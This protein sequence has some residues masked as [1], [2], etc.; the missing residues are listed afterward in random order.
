MFVKVSLALC[1]QAAAAAAD[2]PRGHL[3]LPKKTDEGLWRELFNAGIPPVAV[4]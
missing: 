3:R 2:D 1:F 4:T